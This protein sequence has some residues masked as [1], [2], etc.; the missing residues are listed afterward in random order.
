VSAAGTALYSLT[1]N[2][3]SGSGTIVLNGVS[4][5]NTDNA[6]FIGGNYAIFALPTLGH[7]FTSWSSSGGCVSV[8]NSVVQNTVLTLSSNSDLCVSFT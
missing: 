1:F 8:A 5:P 6:Y 4:Y 7:S 3:I 2:V